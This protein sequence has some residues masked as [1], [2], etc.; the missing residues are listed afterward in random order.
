MC[1]IINI[2]PSGTQWKCPRQWCV[3]YCRGC[4][5]TTRW[6]R[7]GQRWCCGTQ[8]GGNSNLLCLRHCLVQMI[9]KGLRIASFLK[10]SVY[11]AILTCLTI[12]SAQAPRIFVFC[13][14]KRRS[15]GHMPN[16]AIDLVLI[17]C[18]K[19]LNGTSAPYSH[20]AFYEVLNTID[21]GIL[22]F[23][24]KGKLMCWI[25]EVMIGDNDIPSGW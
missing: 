10:I 7:S 3:A 23:K 11:P 24:K 16:P 9:Q 13:S 19:G 14:L 5:H 8:S 2:K 17:D 1:F 25:V 6:G 22:W 15:A 12:F 4:S 21:I 20:Q 18:R